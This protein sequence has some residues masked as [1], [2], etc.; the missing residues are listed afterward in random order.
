[1]RIVVAKPPNFAEIDA[2]F[3]I[4]DRLE[5]LGVL[6]AYGDAIYNPTGGKISESLM[7]HETVHIRRQ[8]A[9]GPTSWWRGYLDNPKFR[10]DEEIPAHQAE[11]LKF[12]ETHPGGLARA[13]RRI[14][15]HHIAA[16]LSGDLYGNLI[17]YQDARGII[18]RGTET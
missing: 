11:Y 4:G 17:R 14:V 6:F 15:L 5:E 9:V 12:C 3:H 2:V 1:M 13:Q 8:S 7:A 10:L 16:R 18:K